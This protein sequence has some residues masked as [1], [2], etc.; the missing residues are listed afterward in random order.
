MKDIYVLGIGHNTPV[1]ID[2]AEACGYTIVG[3]YHYN[4]SRTGEVDH[5]YTVLGSTE[6]LLQESSLEGKQFV[7]SMGDNIIRAKLSSKIK[8]LGGSIPALIHPSCVVSKF[9]NISDGVYISAFSYIQADTTIGENTIILS[10]V[11]IS[12]TNIIGKNCFIAGGST[13]GA[14]TTMKDF[15]FVGQGVLTISSKVSEIG[16]YSYIGAGSLVTKSVEPHSVMMGRPAKLIRR[17]E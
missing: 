1:F 6:D 8:A 10:G 15:V 5:G 9:T 13:I 11:N 2:L 3:L 14:Y 12:H 17:N 7:L 16:E 4:S